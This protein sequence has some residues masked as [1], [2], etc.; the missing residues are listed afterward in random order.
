MKVTVHQREKLD[1]GLIILQ[2][3]KRLVIRGN[4]GVGKTFVVNTLIKE[5]LRGK[6]L[7]DNQKA[8]CSA[9]THKALSVLEG[10]ISYIPGL[11]FSTVHSSL[12][13]KMITDRRTGKKSFEPSYH[14]KYPPLLGVA[15]WIIDEASMIGAKML[16][17]IEE[18]AKKNGTTVIFLGDDKQINP[19]KEDDS[20]VF[21]AGYP[22]IELT[23]IV[24]Q[25]EGNPIITLSR[26]LKQIWNKVPE[27]TEDEKGYLYTSDE[28]AII[29]QLALANGTDEVKYLA[30]ENAEVDRM[31]T[32]VRQRIYGMNPAKIEQ[33]ETIIF[34]EPYRQQYTTNQEVKI[35]TVTVGSKRF[36]VQ[37]EAS[38]IIDGRRQ[39]KL[40]TVMLKLYCINPPIN[41]ETGKPDFDNGIFIIHEDSDKDYKNFVTKLSAHC[42]QR[43]LEYEKRNN[44]ID[45]F[46]KFKYNH[47][48]TVHKSQGSTYKNTVLN[49]GN[50]NRNHNQKEKNRLLYTGTTRASDL[51]ILYNV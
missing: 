38:V 17:D 27:L 46:A 2:S 11:Q 20:P 30:W 13:Y 9:P 26:N 23:E 6:P 25:A 35:E 14:P 43:D 3:S 32:L 36:Y 51:L 39:D 50:I 15:L 37:T 40:E 41:E 21:L 10:K 34:D 44:F 29:E 33:G 4:A 28:F 49:V 12:C 42:H 31:N 5:I 19:V 18:H 45:L 1:E 47:A 24:R 8:V 22:E 7:R 48:L 16:K